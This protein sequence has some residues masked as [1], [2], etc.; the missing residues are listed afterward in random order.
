[1]TWKYIAHFLALCPV[2]EMPQSRKAFPFVFL[3]LRG[4]PQIYYNCSLLGIIISIIPP[5]ETIN[6]SI[7]SK[8]HIFPVAAWIIYFRTNG[9]LTDNVWKL[10]SL[11]PQLHFVSVPYVFLLYNPTECLHY[12]SIL[13]KHKKFSIFQTQISEL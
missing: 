9:G 5:Q 10:Q 1:M 11:E 4:N 2:V 12:L 6:V 3:H 13:S 7:C 8:W